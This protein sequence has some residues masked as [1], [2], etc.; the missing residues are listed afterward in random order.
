MRSWYSTEE[1]KNEAVTW[2]A[3]EFDLSL[4]KCSLSY[5]C[6]AKTRKKRKIFFQKVSEER[7][8]RS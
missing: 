6:L 8:E 5:V 7:K 4:N 1:K 3:S 2:S